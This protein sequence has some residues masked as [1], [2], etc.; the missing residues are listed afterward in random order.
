MTTLTLRPGYEK[1]APTN[2]F[3]LR[4]W[5]LYHQQRTYEALRTHDLVANTYNTGT[6]KTI[7]SLLHLFDLDRT[8][9]NVL[10]IA[11]TNALLAQRV[12][13]HLTILPFNE[14]TALVEEITALYGDESV[15]KTML[16]T[17]TG[18]YGPQ[19]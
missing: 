1:L 14:V 10:F 5:P 7:A 4:D 9:K 3:A 8:G 2:P 6:G 12:V 13:G 15:V 17:A 11:P 19:E 16:E 18:M